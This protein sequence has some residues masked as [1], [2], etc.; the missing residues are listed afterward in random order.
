MEE[1]EKILNQLQEGKITPEQ[2]AEQLEALKRSHKD[3]CCEII[4][5]PS[6]QSNQSNSCCKTVIIKTDCCDVETAC[7]D[8]NQK[9]TITCC[10]A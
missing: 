10:L 7:C 2:A 1:K 8:S 4:V 5:Q 3:K 6:A 9:K